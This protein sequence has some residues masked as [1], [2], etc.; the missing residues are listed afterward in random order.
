MAK[1]RS[2]N[3]NELGTLELMEFDSALDYGTFG[4]LYHGLLDGRDVAV[5]SL[6]HHT[7]NEMFENEVWLLAELGANP[8]TV[9]LLG[10]SVSAQGHRQI[11]ME[12]MRGRN[13]RH[14]LGTLAAS[15]GGSQDLHRLLPIALEIVEALRYLH[16][17]NIIHRDLK[18]TNVLLDERGHIKLADF[19]VGRK[20][21]GRTMTERI[22][23]SRYMAPEVFNGSNYTTAADMYSFGVLLTVLTTL[24]EPF[25]GCTES[26][27]KL[28]AR[29]RD[30]GL[31][32]RLDTN[33]PPAL[34]ALAHQ[35]MHL[36]PCERPTAGA[37]VN[38]LQPLVWALSP[39]PIIPSPLLQ[40]VSSPVGH[41]KVLHRAVTTSNTSS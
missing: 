10:T 39:L 18:T 4:I 37:A 20:A 6:S 8:H 23:T 3:A 27:V 29:I 9:E 36:D 40:I 17:R 34:A 30:E 15:S 7:T 2:I 28:H 12:L 41:P 5:K 26:D 25:A 35:C 38:I 31:R 16:E 32:P 19:G 14:H 11:V 1:V 22:G 21:T 33:C 24:L 13:L